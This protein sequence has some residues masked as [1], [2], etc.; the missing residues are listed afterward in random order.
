MVYRSTKKR[1]MKNRSTKRLQRGGRN[2]NLYNQIY[3]NKPVNTTTQ[4][5]DEIKLMMRKKYGNPP[6]NIMGDITFNKLIDYDMKR[7]NIKTYE[8]Y[9]N[10]LKEEYEEARRFS[11]VMRKASSNE[12][13]HH[14]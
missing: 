9:Y 2:G 12:P 1:S 8:E 6:N 4:W 3:S 7:K 10:K 14:P 5:K 13:P 11:E